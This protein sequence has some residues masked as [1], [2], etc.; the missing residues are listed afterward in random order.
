MAGVDARKLPNVGQSKEIA[1]YRL[2][3]AILVGAIGMQSIAATPSV[4]IDQRH[5]QVVAAEEPPESTRGDRLPLGIPTPPPPRTP[6]SHPH[7]PLH[8]L[9]L[10][11]SAL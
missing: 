5:G 1:H 3:A 7:P 11:P 4:R 2:A 9:L 10:H 8:P 6:P